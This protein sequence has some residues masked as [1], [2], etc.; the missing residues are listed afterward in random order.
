VDP[1][2]GTV[3]FERI[4]A[5][6]TI[7]LAGDLDASCGVIAD[8]VTLS[9]VGPDC[10]TVQVDLCRVAF[11]GAPG[12]LFLLRLK[13]RVESYGGEMTVLEPPPTILRHLRV[14]GLDSVLPI[15]PEAPAPAGWPPHDTQGFLDQK[16][17]R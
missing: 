1:V 8:G 6:L 4:S 11:C 13:R 3:E 9:R 15:R 16:R 12:M 2:A 14:C 5:H 7:R 17:K 10:R